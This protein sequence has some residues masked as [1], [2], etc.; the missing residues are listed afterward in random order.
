V[1]G[2]VAERNACSEP[3]AIKTTS[4]GRHLTGVSMSEA[5]IEADCSMVETKSI[6]CS[7][8]SEARTLYRNAT[9]NSSATVVARWIGKPGAFRKRSNSRW[10]SS[11]MTIGTAT[12][13]MSQRHAASRSPRRKRP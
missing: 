7:A 12:T 4:S 11:P 1:V 9:K 3:T 8:V 13:T 5:A 6:H 10:S 2:T